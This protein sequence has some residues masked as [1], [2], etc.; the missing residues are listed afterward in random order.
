LIRS[1]FQTIPIP[2]AD[3]TLNG[4]ALITQG[5]EDRD[6]LTDQIREFLELLTNEKLTEQQA[7]IA[8]N[9]AKQLKYIPMPTGKAILIG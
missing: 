3:L 2:N 1:K 6:R 5:R 7:N 4:E 9:V 8:E